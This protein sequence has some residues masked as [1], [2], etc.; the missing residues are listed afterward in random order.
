MFGEYVKELHETVLFAL[1][2]FGYSKS[3]TG[4]H[5]VLF[6]RWF[7]LCDKTKLSKK[8]ETSLKLAGGLFHFYN[9]W[10]G[11]KSMVINEDYEDN[12]I[13][14]TMFRAPWS[15]YLY[16]TEVLVNGVWKA[17][18]EGSWLDEHPQDEYMTTFK[19]FDAGKRI[20][21]KARVRGRRKSYSLFWLP[22]FMKFLFSKV[23]EDV[24]INFSEE[25]GKDRGSYKGGTTGVTYPF[26]KNLATSWLEF[27]YKELPKYLRK[28]K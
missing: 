12:P 10:W 26:K 24:T 5:L 17:L 3:V 21:V 11:G 16:K 20:P 15:R 22:S 25:I 7:R 28:E 19:F 6:D 2:P 1:Y 18:P 27:E 9:A 8:F 14:Y 13:F 4:W 23:E